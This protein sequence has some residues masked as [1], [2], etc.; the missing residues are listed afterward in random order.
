MIWLEANPGHYEVARRLLGHAELSST[1]NAYVGFEAGTATRLFAGLVDRL[2]RE[3][4][5]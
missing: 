2:V 4:K 1:L 3:R 5:P